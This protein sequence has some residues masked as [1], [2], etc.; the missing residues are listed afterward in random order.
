MQRVSNTDAWRQQVKS[1]RKHQ[2]SEVRERGKSVF[3]RLTATHCSHLVLQ[4]SRLELEALKE[5]GVPWAYFPTRNLSSDFM[6]PLKWFTDFSMSSPNIP[7]HGSIM[8]SIFFSF[9]HLTWR[10]HSCANQNPLLF[11]SSLFSHVAG[12]FTVT[13]TC[14]VTPRSSPSQQNERSCPCD[15]TLATTL[16]QSNEHAIWGRC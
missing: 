2:W 4:H 10:W 15:K 9:Q 3:C 8:I 6:W 13:F 11:L 5:N 16:I 1:G 14:P 12:H 7:R